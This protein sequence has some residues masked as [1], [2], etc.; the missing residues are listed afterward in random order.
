LKHLCLFDLFSNHYSVEKAFINKV[1]EEPNVIKILDISIFIKNKRYNY[2][3]I[4][5]LII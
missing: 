1:S 3:L 5:K 2:K 4:A